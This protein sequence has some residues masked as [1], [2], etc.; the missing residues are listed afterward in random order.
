MNRRREQTKY[1]FRPPKYS[2]FLAPLIYFISDVYYLHR[3]HRITDVSIASGGKDVLQLCQNGASIL[4]TPNHSDH[5]DPHVLLHLNR[6]F[7]IPVHFIAAREVF[8]A[9]LGI[10][11]KVLQRAGVFSIDREGADIKAIKEAMRIV[12]EAKG[13]LVM[14]PEGE[15]YHLNEKL[16]P[17][18]EGAAT[19]M[20]KTAKRLKKEKKN[21]GCYIIPTAMQY[22][23]TDEI[24]STFDASMEKLEQHLLWAPQKHLDIVERIYKLGEALLSL[25]EKELLDRSLEG[26]LPERLNELR[27]II[28]K[29]I[30]IKYFS[31]VGE[32]AHPERIRKAR[33]KIRSNLLS[34]KNPP[35]QETMESCY[36]DLDKLYFVTQLYSYPGQY[37]RENPTND[38]IAETLLKFEE[39]ILGEYKIKGE[40]RS[41]V[42]F[43]K[44]INVYDFLDKYNQDAKSTVGQVT[45]LI[46]SAIRNILEDRGLK[47]LD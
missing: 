46:E 27:E 40:R 41:I 17:L 16:T 31:K 26:S 9:N 34:D 12:Y 10:N 4:I 6:K 42:T 3:V 36:T 18:N 39:D 2:G 24:S 33:G 15:I 30:E 21:H 1:V 29:E 22:A 7:K 37:I 8:E 35:T 25:K 43:C 32:G 5:S 19:I 44:P 13:P 47:A 28:I 23:Y 38:R 14:F 45:T 11:G 20:L